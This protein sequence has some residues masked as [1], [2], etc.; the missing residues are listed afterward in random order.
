MSKRVCVIIDDD[1][2][3]KLRMIQAKLITKDQGSWS[4]SAVINYTLR[5]NTKMV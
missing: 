1:V 3:K 4:F 2:D 5:M